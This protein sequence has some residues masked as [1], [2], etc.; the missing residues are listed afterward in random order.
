MLVKS[1]TVLFCVIAIII[2]TTAIS[3]RS[4]SYGWIAFFGVLLL[5]I[6]SDNP[7]DFETNVRQVDWNTLLFFATLYV[8][9]NCLYKLGFISFLADLIGHALETFETKFHRIFAVLLLLWVNAQNHY[10]N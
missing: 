4:V 7:K 6:I 2:V 1:I 10:L 3:K 5:V 8:M 9:V